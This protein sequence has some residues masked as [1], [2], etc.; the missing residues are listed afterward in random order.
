MGSIKMFFRQMWDKTSPNNDYFS[1]C[2]NLNTDFNWGKC[3]LQFLD[4]VP[5]LFVT[6]WMSRHC[7]PGVIL[8][9]RPLLERS[10]TV[11]QTDICQLFC[12]SSVLKFI[13]WRM[14]CC[15]FECLSSSLS[16]FLHSS[17][18]PIF[19]FLLV[20]TYFFFLSSHLLSSK[21]QRSSCFFTLFSV[22]VARFTHWILN[23]ESSV[24]SETRNKTRSMRTTKRLKRAYTG[25]M[26]NKWQ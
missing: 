25:I 21:S 7:V 26:K 12:L 19:V 22:S 17:H 14:M 10:T 8:V 9:A 2:L 11:Y 5:G 13:R 24:S 1:C 3:G 20:F 18:F 6:S 16:L 15:L 4:V 23:L